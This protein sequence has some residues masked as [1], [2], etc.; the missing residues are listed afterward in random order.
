M[1]PATVQ[2]TPAP[3]TP[4]APSALPTEMAQLPSVAE[5]R[6]MEAEGSAVPRFIAEPPGSA[7]GGGIADGGDGMHGGTDDRQPSGNGLGSA[8]E[9]EI[10]QIS[11]GLIPIN[12]GRADD[13]RAA[14]P[15]L[16]MTPIANPNDVPAIK[17]P[18]LGR[19][20]KRRV[21][22]MLPKGAGPEAQDSG[23]LQVFKR[24]M[25]PP[26][27]A[28]ACGLVLGLSPFGAISGHRQLA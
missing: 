11:G 22:Q 9:P 12:S 13:D 16:K 19:G 26:L 24:V 7:A 5:L 10:V 28:T 23:W 4:I 20:T 6:R 2:P 18:L 21:T 25:N 1:R 3:L 15:R 8:D 14:A 27:A 17:L